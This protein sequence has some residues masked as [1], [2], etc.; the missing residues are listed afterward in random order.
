MSFDHHAVA[1]NTAAML[2]GGIEDGSADPPGGIICRDQR[3][4]P[5]GLLLEVAAWQVW[6]AAPEPSDAERRAHVK[7][8]LD[9]L[10]R[11]GFVEVHDL[12]SPDWLGPALA[13]L[14]DRGE[15]AVRV[16]LF[17]PM[18]NIERCHEASKT[19]QREQVRLEGGKIFADGTLNSRTAWMLE[20][21][22]DPLPGLPHGKVITPPE[23]L[24]AAMARTMRLGLGLAVHAIGDAA[25]RAVLDAWGESQKARPGDGPWHPLRIEHCELIDEADVPRFAELGVVASVQPCHL[26]ADIEVLKAQLPRH[27]HRVL[28][29]RELIEAGCVPGE[30][31]IFGSDTP[32]VRPHPLDSIQAAVHRRREGMSVQEAVAP[33]QAISQAQAWACFRERIGSAV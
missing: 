3:G 18:D 10:A 17:A 2:A 25:V 6:N 7:V 5:T 28:P 23:E 32:I 1:A 15:L 29:L 21:F 20:P 8:A 31:L 26:L 11:H 19:W 16:G 33:E 30:G 13:D 4:V 14:A 22:A 9:D 27:L 12:F 24:R